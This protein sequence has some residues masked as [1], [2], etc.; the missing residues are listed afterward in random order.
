MSTYLSLGRYFRSKAL[1]LIFI[2]ATIGLSGL[3]VCVLPF[4]RTFG[5]LVTVRCV[6]NVLLGAFITA[7]A[8]IVVY[9][10]GPHKSRPFTNALHAMV[11]VGFLFGTFLVR[12]FLPADATAAKDRD[13]VCVGGGGTGANSN[14]TNAD[15]GVDDPDAVEEDEF[16]WGVQKIAWPF[17]ITGLW[18]IVCSF[19]YLVLGRQEAG[20][21]TEGTRGIFL[22]SSRCI[23][24][25]GGCP[26]KSSLREG[27]TFLEGRPLGFPWGKEHS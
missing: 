26:K 17:L 19:G 6:Q 2:G 27:V 4:L 3:I 20:C 1:K 14:S 25:P 24:S 15:A 13:E 22:S 18:S 7:D 21:P 8:S 5:V 16:L 23:C 10:M 11:G 12:P 9:T